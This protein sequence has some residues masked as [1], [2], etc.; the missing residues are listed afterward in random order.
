MFQLDYITS[1]EVT[2]S[3]LQSQQSFIY[4]GGTGGT[5]GGTFIATEWNIISS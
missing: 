5:S 2:A 1:T 4:S 3:D